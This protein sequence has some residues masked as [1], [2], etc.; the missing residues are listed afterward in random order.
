MNGA[1]SHVEFRRVANMSSLMS[2]RSFL[3]LSAMVPFALQARGATTMPVGLELYSVRDELQR[4]LQGTVRAVAGMGYQF[5]EFYAPY[6]E[7][8]DAQAKDM[9]KLLDDVG[10]RC[11]STHN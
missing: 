4:D 1:L 10:L 2:R 6:Y 7:W 11:S 8:T 9:R 3:A 5:V